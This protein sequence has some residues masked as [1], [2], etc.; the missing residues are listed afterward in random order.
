MRLWLTT[1]WLGALQRQS[2]QA[3][4]KTR[5]SFFGTWRT[6]SNRKVS[7]ERIPPAAEARKAAFPLEGATPE[8]RPGLC[9]REAAQTRVKTRIRS[10]VG[11]S[12]TK[13]VTDMT[14]SPRTPPRSKAQAEQARSMKQA[15]PNNRLRSSSSVAT[16][17]KTRSHL[18]R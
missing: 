12:E 16:K 7:T 6:F 13:Q 18:V 8:A 2:S 5:R 14:R 11:G 17:S 4:A 1:H 3:E 9:D 10:R 15:K